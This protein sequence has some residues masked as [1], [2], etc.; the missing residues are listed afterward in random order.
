MRASDDSRP[1]LAARRLRSALR[2]L[3]REPDPAVRGRVLVSLAW[4][5]SEQGRIELSHRLLDDAEPLLPAGDRAV[6]HA[7]RAVLLHRNGRHDR[8]MR[9]FDA[10][11]AGLTERDHPLDLAKALNNRGLVHLEA[12]EVGAARDDLRRCLRITEEHGIEI[13]AALIRVNL[14]CLDV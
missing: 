5:E 8:A 6:G 3:D 10:A 4:A 14:G 1:A 12:G 2:L 11:V 13:G 9:E 7:P